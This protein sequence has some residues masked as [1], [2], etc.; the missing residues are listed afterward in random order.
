MFQVG[1][2]MINWYDLPF[3]TTISIGYRSLYSVK[4]VTLHSKQLIVNEGIDLD[5]LESFTTGIQTFYETEN[6]TFSS[7]MIDVLSIWSS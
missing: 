7:I 4:N 5:K 3:L 6:V 1:W 2:V